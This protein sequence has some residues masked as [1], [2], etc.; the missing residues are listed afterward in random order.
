MLGRAA[1]ASARRF[2]VFEILSFFV[3]RL[4]FLA[5]AALRT[6]EVCKSEHPCDVEAIEREPAAVLEQLANKNKEHTSGKAE[7]EHSLEKGGVN[8]ARRRQEVVYVDKNDEQPNPKFGCRHV[9]TY[10]RGHRTW[11]TRV[12]HSIFELT[13]L[14][15]CLNPKNS[16][17]LL[18]LTTQRRRRSPRTNLICKVPQ[19]F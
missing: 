10:G 15:S 18:S 3:L 14:P 1:A 9:T 19:N 5:L 12:A 6:A 13:P 16:L 2:I 7:P 8:Y 4:D 11:R 17:L